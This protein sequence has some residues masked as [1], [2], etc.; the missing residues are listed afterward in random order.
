[1]KVLNVFYSEEKVS[2]ED[3]ETFIKLLYPFAPH[4]T[5]EVNELLGSTSLVYSTWPSFDE[6][7]TKD[8]TFEMIVQVNGKL[9]DKII[10][11][12][13]IT[14]EEMVTIAKESENIKK[15]TEGKEIVK[16]IVVPNKLVNIVIK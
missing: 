2:K 4:I 6:E 1:M 13:G 12:S 16:V 9:R 5:E 11:N 14:R 8:D 10:V 3:Y 7:K 15:Y